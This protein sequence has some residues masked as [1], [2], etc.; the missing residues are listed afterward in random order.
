MLRGPR[1]VYPAFWQQMTRLKSFVLD[2]ERFHLLHLLLPTLLDQHFQGLPTTW[3]HLFIWR[4]EKLLLA[5]KSG[6]SAS[7]N[8]VKFFVPDIT[9]RAHAHSLDVQ[10][11]LDPNLSPLLG[12]EHLAVHD[13]LDALTA[14]HQLPVPLEKVVGVRALDGLAHPQTPCRRWQS[15]DRAAG[16]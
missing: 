16:R 10:E 4:K 14:V 15:C 3:K 9:G 12:G 8:K 13:L 1:P 2:A 11:H 7:R 6:F 5:S